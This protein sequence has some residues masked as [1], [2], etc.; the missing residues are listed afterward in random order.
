MNPILK[1]VARILAA[2]LL[3]GSSA[4][5]VAAQNPAFL[6][7]AQPGAFRVL[8]DSLAPFDPGRAEPKT[9][10]LQ[11]HIIE[12]ARREVI[13]ILSENNSCSAWFQQSE[14]QAAAKFRSLRFTVDTSGTADILKVETSPHIADV[15]QPYV[16]STGQNV[17]WGSSITLNANGAF[18]RDSAR[19]RVVRSLREQ[20]YF[21]SSKSLSV[22]GFPGATVSARMLTLLHEFAH[23][24][25]LLPIDAGVPAAVQISVQN[26]QTVIRHCD[27]QI[28][29]HATGISPF[30]REA[31]SLPPSQSIQRGRSMQ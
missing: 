30:S 24:L 9:L 25:N 26:T 31:P 1:F 10:S 27:S 28:R 6:V 7:P 2:C 14:P 4:N 19:V 15:Y 11:G 23:I 12:E 13:S 18:F 22:G 17:G 29:S 3:L 5:Q 16:A 21:Q 8:S 20:G